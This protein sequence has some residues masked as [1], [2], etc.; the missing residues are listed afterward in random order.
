MHNVSSTN[1]AE[2]KAGDKL[3]QF[4]MYKVEYPAVE[5]VDDA[6]ELFRGTDSE[7]GEGAFGSTGV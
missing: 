7:R 5:L 3:A 6:E 1:T 4:I 2:I